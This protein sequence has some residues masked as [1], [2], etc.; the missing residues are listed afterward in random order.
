[1]N[2]KKPAAVEKADE[3]LK[4]IMSSQPHLLNL[5]VPDAATGKTIGDFIAALRDR[6]IEMHSQAR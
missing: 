4:V 6:L 5:T 2:S 3:M 1:M